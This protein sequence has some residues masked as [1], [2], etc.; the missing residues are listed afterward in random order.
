MIGTAL[1]ALMLAVV[2]IYGVMSYMVNQRTREIGLRMALGAGR[3][4]IA[5]LVVGRAAL[6]TGAGLILGLLGA[7]AIANVLSSMLFGVSPSDVVTYGAVAALL[8]VVALLA[9]Y[10]P[11]RRAMRVDPVRALRAD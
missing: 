3:Q 10:V 4:D 1:V 6:L 11:A 7:R 2:G 5:R 8:V 9:S